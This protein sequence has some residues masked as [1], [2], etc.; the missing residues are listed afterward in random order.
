MEIDTAE[1]FIQN[2]RTRF[3][4]MV[5]RSNLTDNLVFIAVLKAACA[6]LGLNQKQVAGALCVSQMTLQRW[7]KSQ[8]L[9]IGIHRKPHL[10]NLCQK[11]S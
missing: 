4:S 9:P 5:E 8:G 1:S 7:L 11:I 6:T 3:I 10:D 2:T